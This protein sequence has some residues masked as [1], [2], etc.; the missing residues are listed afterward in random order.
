MRRPQV[1]NGYTKF[2]YDLFREVGED[3]EIVTVQVEGRYFFAPGVYSRAPEDCYPDEE[4]CEIISV[5][6]PNNE[7]YY[8]NLSDGEKK[9]IKEKIELEVR[10]GDY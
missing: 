7:D 1:I 5:I 4:D 10:E 3:E 6:G 9:D 8:E 2:A